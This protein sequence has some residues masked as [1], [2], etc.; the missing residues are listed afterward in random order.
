VAKKHSSSASELDVRMETLRSVVSEINKEFKQS[1]ASLAHDGLR[2]DVQGFV[3]TGL[4]ML[5]LILHG[6][7]PLG[8]MIEISGRPGMGKSTLA[9]HILANCQKMGGTAIVLDSEN[10]W[11]TERVKELGL[12][13]SAL[14]QFEARTV[15]EGFSLIDA[16]L[17]KLEKLNSKG[18]EKPP[19]VIVW[20]TIAASPCSRDIDPDRAGT[21]M[22][23]P[24]AIHIGIKK[25]YDTLRESRASLVFINQII[26]KMSSFG[27]PTDETP[28]GWG[29]KFGVS[30]A[31]RLGT[32]ANGK[33]VVAG[34]HV[35]NIVKAK[36]T[37]N[38]IPGERAKDFEARIPLLFEGGFND[39][40]ANL[41]F[42]AEGQA[43]SGSS[44]KK[45]GG[46]CEYLQKQ[47]RGIYSAVYNEE[48][49][50]FRPL[51]FPAVLDTHDGMREWLME[52]V[53]DRF[54]K[55]SKTLSEMASEEEAES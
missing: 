8:R 2:G 23:K 4:L 35:G 32:V 3:P 53:K 44:S 38:K 40:I 47:T 54:L 34:E 19:V 11:T 52:M 28:G 5:D 10:S 33:I 14:I 27:G 7:V 29:I 15:E 45:L 49:L 12:N 31:I 9:A 46:D 1:V 43:M 16:T 21:A 17:Q 26:T 30:Q 25:I 20:D 6:G 24:R 50:K 18:K 22:D 41:F 36:I 37:K 39:D 42:L 48:E 55:P 51:G 13:A